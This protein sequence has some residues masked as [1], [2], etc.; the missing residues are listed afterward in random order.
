M[1]KL[2]NGMFTVSK[3]DLKVGMI[4]EDRC[5]YHQDPPYMLITQVTKDAGFYFIRSDDPNNFHCD[6]IASSFEYTYDSYSEGYHILKYCRLYT[7]DNNA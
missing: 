7:G 3:K 2:K 1:K 6:R 5:I 4:L